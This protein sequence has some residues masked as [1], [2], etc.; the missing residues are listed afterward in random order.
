MS[1]FWKYSRPRTRLYCI[2]EVSN[3]TTIGLG[4]IIFAY[5]KLLEANAPDIIN[6]SSHTSKLKKSCLKKLKSIS[7]SLSPRLFFHLVADT[8]K[9]LN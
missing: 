9:K 8:S 3:I 4:G 1:P 7:S 6:E 5:L 2:T